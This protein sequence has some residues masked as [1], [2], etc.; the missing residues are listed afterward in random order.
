MLTDRRALNLEFD[1]F[2]NL[3]FVETTA[4]GSVNLDG[5]LNIPMLGQWFRRLPMYQIR[6]S[7]LLISV[8]PS[9]TDW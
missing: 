9:N 6:H 8:V 3:I 1:V 4:H 2:F 5:C 7:S